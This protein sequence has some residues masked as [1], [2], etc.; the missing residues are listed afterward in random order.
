MTRHAPG[1]GFLPSP[2]A[3]VDA[4]Q[5]SSIALLELALLVVPRDL[6]LH[7]NNI[8]SLSDLLDDPPPNLVASLLAQL[9]SDRCRDLSILTAAYRTALVRQ[10]GDSSLGRPADDF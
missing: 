8:G 2:A 10:P 3:L 9:I 4:P 7:D 5:L 6:D 1:D